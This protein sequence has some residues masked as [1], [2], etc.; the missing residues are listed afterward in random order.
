MSSICIIP[1]RGGSKRIPRKNIRDFCGKPIIA[2]SIETALQSGLF[3]QVVVSTDDVEIADISRQYGAETPFMRPAALADDFTGTGVVFG[4]GVRM[5]RDAGAQIDYAC[6]IYPTAPLLQ[7][8]YLRKGFEFVRS[9]RADRAI[10]VTL[11]AS[12]IFRSMMLNED[13]Y[14]RMLW[15]EYKMTRSQDL[16]EVFHDAGQFYWARADVLLGKLNSEKLRI[17]PVMLPRW[18][19]V[20]IDTPEDWRMA[21]YLYTLTTKERAV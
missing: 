2:Y 17:I 16:P 19:V 18:L 12:P 6:C 11:Y 7:C 3:D 5:L 9:G 10:S 14:V 8:K 4:H 21:E 13:G 20:D 15:P 1:A